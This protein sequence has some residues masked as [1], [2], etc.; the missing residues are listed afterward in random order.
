MTYMDCIVYYVY[1]YS[2]LCEK[3]CKYIL[4]LFYA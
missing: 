3:Q 4:C 2:A 1:I